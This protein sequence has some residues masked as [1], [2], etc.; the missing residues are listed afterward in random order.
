MNKSKNIKEQIQDWAKETFDFYAKEDEKQKK[1]FYTQSPLNNITSNPE[2]IVMGINPGSDGR[3]NKDFSVTE[4]LKGNVEWDKHRNWKYTQRIE[5]F[6]RKW[7]GD[8]AEEIFSDDNQIVYINASCFQTSKASALGYDLLQKSL[9]HTIGLVELLKPK[10]LLCLSAKRFFSIEKSIERIN[11]TNDIILGTL[12]RIPII[13]IP[14]PSARLTSVKREYIKQVIALAMENS[15]LNIVDKAKLIN[16]RVQF[17]EIKVS[18]SAPDILKLAKKEIISILGTLFN[19]REKTLCFPLNEDLE[20]RITS[21][22]K[23]YIGIRHI[24]FDGKIKYPND[25][26]PSCEKYVNILRKFGFNVLPKNG[27]WIG[28]KRFREF[29]YDNKSITKNIAIEI[30][31]IKEL[32][33]VKL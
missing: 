29:G 4:F 24:S 33:S 20:I 12:G 3:F 10:L 19:E 8:R 16:E 31:E 5:D 14:H 28:T 13:G 32:V 25:R 1:G 11:L 6:L 15:H 18:F 27:V 22:E 21:C 30:R 2:I 7:L 9:P 26:Y 23:G 17:K